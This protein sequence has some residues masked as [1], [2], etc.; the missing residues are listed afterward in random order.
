MSLRILILTDPIGK[1]SYAPRLRYLC[2]YLADKG[3]DIEVYTEQFQSYD[4]P[5]SY[6]IYEKPI[7][8]HT[9]WQWA[10]QSFWSLLSDWR[11][12]Q[13]SKWLSKQVKNKDF[14][15]VFCTTFSTFP[16]RAA[17]EIATEK[18]IP[19][20]VDIRDLDEQVPGAQYQSHRQWWARPF[21]LWYKYIN[22][23]R[24]NRILRT[25]NIISTVSPWH[26]DFIRQFN[27]NVHLIYNG[28]DPA[29]FYPAYQ[30]TDEFLVSYIGKIYEFQNMQLIEQA[31]QELQLPNIHLNLHTPDNN[32]INISE[33]G[34]EIRRSSIALVLTNPKAKG[35]MT[36]KFFEA[37]GCEKPILC[38]PSDNGILAD[39]I[40]KTNAGIAS[41]ALQEIKDFIL[42]KYNEWQKNGFTH[43]V[44][45][46][47]EQFSREKQAEQFEQLFQLT[48]QPIISVI[49][50]IYNAA[51][52]LEKCLQSLVNQTYP[53][54]QIILIN[55]GSTDHSAQIAQEFAATDPRI[56]YYEQSN[57]GQSAARNLGL[58][59]AKGEYI[60]FVDSDDYI[61][62]D[63]YEILLHNIG[64]NDCIQIGY[65]R[66]TP[67]GI[68]LEE[69]LPRYFYQFTSPCMR[70]YRR[71][72]FTQYA[73]TFQE[74]MIYEDVIFSLDFWNS[75]P[76]YI[77]IPY[78]GY[79]YTS[80]PL[81]TTAKRNR[82]KEQELFY[83]LR[84]RLRHAS[85]F[86]H[87][88]VVLLTITRLKFHFKRYD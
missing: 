9:T 59:F 8:H 3:Y 40:H 4:F 85:T 24:R 76:T 43:Q 58:Q 51:E 17:Q 74:G 64:V 73:L 57:K 46:N 52:Y 87:W 25:A 72:I 68:I 16:L 55:D 88:C 42:E 30:S 56:E 21:S 29:Q 28:F 65:R 26:V 38:V 33:V 1:P 60:S 62:A 19:F 82:T 23:R 79:N 5:H 11:N 27:P 71:S 39:T 69:K 63:F 78:T 83:I 50:P 80:N 12:R 20:F 18:H 84:Q 86:K 45:I 37:L 61:D 54:L 14:D 13:F 6:P 48:V 2:Q 77:Q 34:D 31:I 32:P 47:K 35:M 36:T 53:N 67:Q 66:V 22:I 15:L 75:N 81:S 7:T 41:S 49:L 70:L 44:V 10:I